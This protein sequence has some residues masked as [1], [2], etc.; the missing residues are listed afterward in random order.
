MLVYLAGPISG[1]NF[2]G[3]T[4]WREYAKGE[5]AQFGIKAL[6]PLRF[7]EHMK[8]IGI[9]TDAAKETERL[10]S[11][12]STPKGLTIR[13]RWDAMRC[14]V[15]LVNLLAAPKVSIGTMLE[16]AWANSKDI[17][18]V[19]AMEDAPAHTIDHNHLGWLAALIDGE[20]C[21]Y[22]VRRVRDSGSPCFEFRIQV[23]M[24]DKEMIDAAYQRSNGLGVITG[25][26]KR[27]NNPQWREA[28]RWTVN[29]KDAAILAQAIYPHLV[30]KRAQAALGF[31][32]EKINA[33]FRPEGHKGHKGFQR[34]PPE[35][36]QEQEDLYASW[37]AAQAR[38][39][40]K[41]TPPAAYGNPHEHA[42]VNQLV[43]FRV[44]TLWDA[45][46]VTRQL[47]AA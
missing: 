23:T 22:V 19:C 33:G 10:K 45:V 6:S 4:D 37:K 38:E 9:F 41:F 28:W 25:P 13:D 26:Y 3:A 12:M 39:P 14:D 34:R 16:I 15:L 36:V 46:D 1:L 18:I 20:G 21:V 8:A 35:I 27:S 40:V 2:E 43:G 17:P 47:L 30:I 32:I 29:N 11:P 44:P 31:E 7:Q 24:T 42:M 5:L